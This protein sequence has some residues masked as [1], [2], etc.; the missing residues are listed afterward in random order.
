[1]LQAPIYGG[2]LGPLIAS[3]P[4]GPTLPVPSHRNNGLLTI[5]AALKIYSDVSLVYRSLFSS[6]CKKNK[7]DCSTVF[8]TLENIYKILLQ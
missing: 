6:H 3:S 7:R 2:R 5:K 8:K 1:M 4:G